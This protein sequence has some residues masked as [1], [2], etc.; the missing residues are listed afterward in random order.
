VNE[1][2][3]NTPR[4]QCSPLGAN[5][6][7][8]VSCFFFL[9]PGGGYPQRQR[10]DP[11]LRHGQL[12]TDDIIDFEHFFQFLVLKTTPHGSALKKN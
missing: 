7:P 12:K 5:F 10:L 8:D 2:V 4:E 6:N 1:G 11:A 9:P 3:N